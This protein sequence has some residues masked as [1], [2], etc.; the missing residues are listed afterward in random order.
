MANERLLVEGSGAV[1]LAALIKTKERY[2]DKNI[3]ILVSGGNV[4]LKTLRKV[5]CDG[6]G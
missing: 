6:S 3:V 5:M 4:G 1:P 2:V